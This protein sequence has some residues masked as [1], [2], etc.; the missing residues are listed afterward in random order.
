MAIINT[1][2]MGL[3][4]RNPFIVAASGITNVPE[5]IQKL[6]SLGAG[7]IVLK[8]LFEEQIR[9]YLASAQQNLEMAHPEA[10]AFLENL[11]MEAGAS[12]Y[13]QLIRRA[14]A[15][16][17]DVPI[18]ASINC[19][20]PSRWVDFAEQIEQAGARALE[21]NIALWPRSPQ[22]PGRDLEEQVLSIVRQVSVRTR[23]PLAVKLGPYYT[24]PGNLI[25]RLAGAGARSVVLFN[26]F[27]RFDFKLDSM[28]VIPGPTLSSPQDY[29]ESLRWIANLYGKVDCELVAAT[30]VHS[31][32]T[33]LKMIAAG[34][35]AVQVC[36][37]LYQKGLGVLERLIEEFSAHLDRRNIEDINAFRGCLSYMA[38]NREGTY[39]RLQYIRSLTG[40][41]E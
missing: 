22:E 15:S 2:Y 41:M 29:Y 6:V 12:E 39:E 37:L 18:I 14:V 23:L 1:T 28:T 24:N 34:A 19:I 5:N 36:S 27:Y 9:S 32:E 20:S 25:E 21:L 33:A 10:E 17:G 13:L 16:A 4:L 26:R 31:A 7:A 8:S 11:G 3:P 38:N 35:T 40:G 30:G